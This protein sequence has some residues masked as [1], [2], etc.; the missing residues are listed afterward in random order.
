MGKTRKNILLILL[1]ATFAVSTV[2]L[3]Y[4]YFFRDRNLSGEWT[5][6]LDFTKEAAASAYVWLQEIEA[7]SVSL[8][9]LEL[10][11]QGLTVPVSLTL[12]Q[13][14][15]AEGTF[16]CSVSQESYEACRRRAYEAMAAAFR[17][18]LS[19]RLRLAGYTGG[20][21]PEAVEAL[22]REAFGM[23]TED[24][25]TTCGPA[26]LPTLEEL[27]AEYVGSGVCRISGG[28]LT[29]QYE[30]EAGSVMRREY[31]VRQGDR[32]ILTGEVDEGDAGSF[33]AT[34]PV[35]YILKDDS[36]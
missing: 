3:A 27:Q 22:A 20:T 12:E 23:S 36:E 6:E 11:M 26:L 28:I 10:S 19:E 8:E 13:G 5:T 7:V 31:Y 32:L 17:E 25:L 34:Y 4:L 21:D 18:L 30:T 14:A 15:G 33:S 24:Y 16:R 2:L 29:R 9:E 1:L 35:L